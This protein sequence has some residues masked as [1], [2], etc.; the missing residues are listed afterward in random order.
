MATTTDGVD[1]RLVP[2]LPL[3]ELVKVWKRYRPKNH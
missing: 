2:A 3:D 1:G